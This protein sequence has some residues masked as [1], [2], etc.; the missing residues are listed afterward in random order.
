MLLSPHAAFVTHKTALLF[1]HYILHLLLSR[2]VA[3]LTHFSAFAGRAGSVTCVRCFPNQ[4]VGSG[5]IIVLLVVSVFRVSKTPV[6]PLYMFS[7]NGPNGGTLATSEQL[8]PRIEAKLV[9]EKD[10][11]TIVS[12][13]CRDDKMRLLLLNKPKNCEIAW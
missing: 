3:P 6:R 1:L 10:I 5:S 12:A 11:Y 13:W 9:L 8:H 7:A 4:A 2:H